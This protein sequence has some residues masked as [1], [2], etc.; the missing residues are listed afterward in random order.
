MKPA[1]SLSEM[2]IGV[3]HEIIHQILSEIVGLINEN[4][5]VCSLIP[6]KLVLGR[7]S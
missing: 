5:S 1:I 3:K 7:F 4:L 2:K 6:L